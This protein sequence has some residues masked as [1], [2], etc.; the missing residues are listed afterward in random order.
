MTKMGAKER[1][2]ATA[3]ARLFGADRTR[4]IGTVYLWNTA[5]LTFLWT[6]TQDEAKYIDPPVSD[7]QLAHVKSATPA[8]VIEFLISLPKLAAE[9]AG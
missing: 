9:D 4:E 6:G 7:V 2:E 3:I 8:E 1:L 5:E